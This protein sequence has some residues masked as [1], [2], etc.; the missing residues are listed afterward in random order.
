MADNTSLFPPLLPVTPR[1]P[2]Q[3]VNQP[4]P[5]QL[6]GLRAALLAPTNVAPPPA[7][8]ANDVAAQFAN[9]PAFNYQPAA[10]AVPAAAPA[11]AP[12][13]ETPTAPATPPVNSQGTTPVARPAVRAPRPA[14]APAAV[15]PAVAPAVAGGL[16]LGLAPNSETYNDQGQ[17][18]GSR[19]PA[20]LP[21]G[22]LPFA[23]A[24]PGGTVGGRFVDPSNAIALGYAMQLAYQQQS[25]DNLLGAFRRSDGLAA[26]KRALAATIGQ[27]NFGAVQGQGTNTINSAL[28]SIGAAGA[29][30]GGT[31]EAARIHE[32]GA[33]ARN[34]ATL[35]QQNEQFLDTPRPTG[36]EPSTVNIGGTN[37]PGPA[38]TTY[39]TPRQGLVGPAAT[40][41][42]NKPKEGATGTYQGKPVVYTN[43]QW[44]YKQ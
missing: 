31:V 40:R 32:E 37:L 17:V 22:S 28:G 44:A 41:S 42:A 5:S 3:P 16:D 9:L 12:T 10:P 35:A 7:I 25:I 27:N 8:T 38:L 2:A 6:P 18:V 13:V 34:D 19:G 20:G 14:A 23:G 11:P 26:T 15:A 39:S 43:G 21:T 4:Q 24:A 30:A 33:T 1:Q 29:G 36:T